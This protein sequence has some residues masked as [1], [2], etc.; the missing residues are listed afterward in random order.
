[1][2]G[3]L[4]ARVVIHA[5]NIGVNATNFWIASINRTVREI[6]AIGTNVVSSCVASGGRIAQLLVACISI[7]AIVLGVNTLTSVNIASIISANVAIIAVLGHGSAKTSRSVANIVHAIGSGASYVQTSVAR[8]RGKLA[9]TIVGI[10]NT[11]LMAHVSIEAIHRRVNTTSSSFTG[12][13]VAGI[14]GGT[15]N[16]RILASYT[17]NTS[18]LLAMVAV[19]ASSGRV[20]TSIPVDI[21]SAGSGVAWVP[22]SARRWA[23]TGRSARTETKAACTA[24]IA[25]DSLTGGSNKTVKNSSKGREAWNL[26]ICRGNSV[27]GSGN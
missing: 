20:K 9:S 11:L 6:I 4:G 13:S 8:N 18:S 24:R 10:A 17:S 7:I 22:I 2:T 5:G 26:R 15:S 25:W 1:L 21:R 16:I 14:G 27:N 3:I 12:G 23:N 19:T